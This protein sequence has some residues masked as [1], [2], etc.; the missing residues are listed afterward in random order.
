MAAC[1]SAGDVP[2]L[3][4][5]REARPHPG[6]QTAVEVVRVEPGGLEGLRRERR[7]ASR[8]AVEEDRTFAVDRAGLGGEPVDLDVARAGETPRLVLVGRRTSTSW[9]S[10]SRSSSDAP[11]GSISLMRFDTTDLG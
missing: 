3:G 5:D 1:A 11:L 4:L 10:R 7:A 6:D 9:T 8:A 2:A